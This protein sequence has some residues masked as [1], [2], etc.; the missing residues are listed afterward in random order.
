MALLITLK[1]KFDFYYCV[2]QQYSK[3]IYII[4]CYG[5]IKDAN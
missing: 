5:G 2:K 1:V 4:G 3:Y